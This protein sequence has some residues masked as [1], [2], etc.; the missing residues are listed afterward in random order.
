M[1]CNSCHRLE[2]TCHVT[3]VAGD[4]IQ[5]RDLCEECFKAGSPEA[6]GLVEVHRD[7]RCQY[8]DGQ[9]CA[10]ATDFLGLATGVQALKFMCM[11]C[12]MEHNRYAQEH[13]PKGASGL[14]QQEQLDLLRKLDKE[15]DAHM[16]RWASER[17]SR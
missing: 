2:A 3:V 10:G 11:P 6:R 13:F 12:L 1:L 7:A 4:S 9:P 17:R 14:S 15:A 8:C 16:K 5:K